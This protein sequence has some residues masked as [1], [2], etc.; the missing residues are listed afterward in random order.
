ML[1]GARLAR[2]SR[3]PSPVVQMYIPSAWPRSTTFVSPATTSTPAVRAARAIASTSPRSSSA[4]NP[5]SST[6]E[7]L[8]ASGR[9]P[10]TA[11]SLTVPLTARSPIEPPGKRSGLT[12]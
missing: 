3:L 5:S 2:G 4:A 11:R 10:E 6:S 7:R 9:A 1:V 12:T 8:S